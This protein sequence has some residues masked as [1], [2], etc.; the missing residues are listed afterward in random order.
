[1]GL[2]IGMAL[3]KVPQ[4]AWIPMAIVGAPSRKGKMKALDDT[5]HMP[6]RIFDSAPPQGPQQGIRM[7]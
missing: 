2:D 6:Y 5:H 7:D 1:M 3:A 4:W